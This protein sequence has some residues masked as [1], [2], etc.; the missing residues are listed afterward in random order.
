MNDLGLANVADG[1]FD[2]TWLPSVDSPSLSPAVPRSAYF[3]ETGRLRASTSSPTTEFFHLEVRRSFPLTAEIWVRAAEDQL[4]TGG[5]AS[6]PLTFFVGLET[7]RGLQWVSSD[8]VGGMIPVVTGP[9]PTRS[10]LVTFRFPLACFSR[11][12]DVPIDKILLRTDWSGGTRR[13]VFDDVE[14][15]EDLR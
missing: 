8:G 2:A 4:G 9:V 3:G 1:A 5:A 13:Y 15:V 12:K 14:I 10:V 11:Q 6:R 7:E